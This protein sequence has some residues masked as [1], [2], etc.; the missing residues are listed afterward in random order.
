MSREFAINLEDI[1]G[2]INEDKYRGWSRV[3]CEDGLSLTGA[4]C[5][6]YLFASGENRFFVLT[7]G[8]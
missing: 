4:G 1:S 7:V 5:G 8:E 6:T 3:F 2:V